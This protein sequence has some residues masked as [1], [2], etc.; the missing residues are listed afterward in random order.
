[1]SATFVEDYKIIILAK[2]VEFPFESLR[3]DFYVGK[4]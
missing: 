3:G 2:I 1:M 4:Q